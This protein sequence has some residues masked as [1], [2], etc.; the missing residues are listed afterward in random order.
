MRWA[1]PPSPL[2]IDDNNNE[3]DFGVT[4]ALPVNGWYAVGGSDGLAPGALM[5]ATLFGAETVVWRGGDGSVHAWENR[6]RHRGMRLTLGFVD[7]DTLACRY[8]GWR[9]GAG[10]ECVSIPAHPGMTPPD[11]FRV[12]THACHERHGLIWVSIAADEDQPPAMDGIG[13]DV[14]FCRSLIVRA[15]A[16]DVAARA[17]RAV[18]PPFGQA[19]DSGWRP[20]S[21]PDGDGHYRWISGDGDAIEVA[22]AGAEIAPGV[23]SIEAKSGDGEERVVMALQP[24]SSDKCGV[25]ILAGGTRPAAR[26]LHYAGWGQRLRWFLENPDAETSSWRPWA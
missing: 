26:R 2:I 25:H 8:H 22:Y 7:G 3:K 20:A 16:E 11:S 21:P 9:Y 18:F 24:I 13:D 4:G 19:G 10:G 17:L 12:S 15:R 23:L 5:P 6:C 14:F 1:S